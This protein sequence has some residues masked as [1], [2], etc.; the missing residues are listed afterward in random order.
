MKTEVKEL[1]KKAERS[2]SA[3]ERLF[4]DGDYDFAVSRAYYAMFYCAEALLLTKNLSFSKHS[5]VI[6][7]FGKEFVKTGILDKKLQ[8]YLL[9]TFDARQKSDYDFAMYPTKEECKNI[10]KD[11]KLFLE[12]TKEYLRS[13]NG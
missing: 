13:E 8:R 5:A 6:S 12:K 1:F 7:S 9:D 2:F 4:K 10:L 11:A 3:A